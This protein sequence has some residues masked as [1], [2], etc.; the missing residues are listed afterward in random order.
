MIRKV[1][2]SN[3]KKFEQQEFDIPDHLVIAGPNNSGKTSLLQAI[4]AWS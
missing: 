3:F 4:A 2:V 1:V